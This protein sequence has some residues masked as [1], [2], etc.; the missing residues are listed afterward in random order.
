VKRADHPC[1]PFSE[2]SKAELRDVAALQ[3]D[4]LSGRALEWLRAYRATNTGI[5]GATEVQLAPGYV[6]DAAALA[7]FQWRFNHALGCDGPNDW[8]MHL[9]VFEVKTS[10]S[11]F[12][13][14]FGPSERHE[15]RKT[16]VACLHWCVAY[17]GICEPEELP[18]FWGLLR[19]GPR[20]GLKEVKAPKYKPQGT[21]VLNQAA[22]DILWALGKPRMEDKAR[23]RV[24]DVCLADYQRY[25]P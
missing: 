13:A 2:M 17:E 10:R 6:A 9:C 16:P 1:L 8:P 7:S 22:M 18:D 20:G 3:H 23:V 15:N 4:R 11:D 19:V 21:T 5:R 12:L 24:C 25:K 14:T